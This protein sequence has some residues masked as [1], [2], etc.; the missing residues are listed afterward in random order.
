MATVKELLDCAESNLKEPSQLGTIIA[1]AQIK[2]YNELKAAGANDK[3]DCDEALE[4]YPNC[5]LKLEF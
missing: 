4:K 1:R 5:A 2:Q 3:D